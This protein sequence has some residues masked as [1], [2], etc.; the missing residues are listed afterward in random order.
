MVDVMFPLKDS[1]LLHLAVETMGSLTVRREE[2]ICPPLE[3]VNPQPDTLHN[4]PSATE[5]LW[6]GSGAMD[7]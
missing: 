7:T 3:L 5:A 6:R 1:L 4:C 2:G